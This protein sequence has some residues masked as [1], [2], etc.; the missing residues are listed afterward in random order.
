MNNIS[1]P[2]VCII[3]LNWNGWQDT[4]RCLESVFCVHYPDIKVIT[5]DNNSHDGSFEQIKTWVDTLTGEK[6]NKFT[7]I[8]TESN[9]GYSGG[10]NVGLRHALTQEIDLFMLLNNDTVVSEDFLLPLV[11]TIKNNP[12]LGAVTPKIFYLH[13]PKRIWAAGGEISWWKGLVKNRGQ[14]EKDKGQYNKSSP[15]DYASGCCMLITRQALEKVGLLDE[16]FFAYF[17]DADWCVR[18]RRAG[19]QILYE[20]S[21][22]IWHIAG[23]STRGNH[24]QK[25]G[26]GRTAPLVYYLNARNNLW[27]IR[28]YTKGIARITAQAIFAFRYLVF[29]S[30]IFFVLRRWNK[31]KMIWQGTRDGL[32]G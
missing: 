23:A 25:R 4:I 1:Y 26:E 31:L 11:K 8:R 14:Y 27:F 12:N 2:T 30:L 22:T 7:L 17:E 6:T 18:A 16:R 32:H 20:P 24:E 3:I 5:C 29:Y 9:L 15:V 19:Y 21:S 10:N 28:R 13:E